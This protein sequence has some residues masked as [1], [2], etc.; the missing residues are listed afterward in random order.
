MLALTFEGLRRSGER[1]VKLHR[2]NQVR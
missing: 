2:Q 1:I